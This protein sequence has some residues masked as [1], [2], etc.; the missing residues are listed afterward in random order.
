MEITSFLKGA[1][2]GF[3]MAVP[4][5]PIGI[6]C[7][8]KTLNEGRSQGLIV[9]LGAATADLFFS[10]VAAFGLTYISDT[11]DE[12]RVLIRLIGGVILLLIGIKMFRKQPADPEIKGY[13]G[14]KL[15]TYISI[16]FLT[17]TNPLTIFAF[18]AVFSAFGLTKGLGL[19]SSSLLVAGVFTGSA[20]WFLLLSSTVAQFRKKLNF[21]GLKWVNRVTG[22]FII[23]AGFIAMGSLI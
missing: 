8:R 20:L 18:I 21:D 7:I 6:I 5:G 23:C 22:I 11:V 9:G 1:L 14:G 12:Q 13:I 19:F 3:L 4:I 15:K 10:G 16:M 2:I 17:L